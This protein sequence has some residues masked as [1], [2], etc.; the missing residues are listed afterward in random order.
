MLQTTGIDQLVQP[1]NALKL[2]GFPSPSGPPEPGAA[3]TTTTTAAN[4]VTTTQKDLVH[5]LIR[6]EGV[7][8]IALGVIGITAGYRGDRE[9]VGFV[10]L[11][12]CFTAF[13]DGL[14]SR[15]VIGGGEMRHWVFLPFMLG[16]AVGLL[17]W[18]E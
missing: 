18:P 8:N 10:A 1:E 7:R 15:A 6:R 3:T 9:L 5:G 16:T 17:G 11:C 12:G 13:A 4:A 2:W 14:I